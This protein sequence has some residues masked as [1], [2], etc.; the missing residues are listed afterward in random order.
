[1]TCVLLEPVLRELLDQMWESIRPS[2]YQFSAEVPLF[3]AHVQ[4]MLR[5]D[6]LQIA[7]LEDVFTYELRCWELALKMREHGHPLREHSAE[8]E[9]HHAPELL[10]PPLSNLQAPPPGISKGQYRV[11]LILRGTRIAVEAFSS[12]DAHDQVD[13]SLSLA[14]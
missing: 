14:T 12:R 9:F 1:M 3:T 4:G 2:S 7:Y 11:R 6:Q 5:Q 13:N 8:V 10:L